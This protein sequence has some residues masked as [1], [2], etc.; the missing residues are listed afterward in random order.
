MNKTILSRESLLR[1]IAQYYAPETCQAIDFQMLIDYL[2]DREGADQ[3]LRELWGEGLVDPLSSETKP[4][5]GITQT[6]TPRIDGPIKPSNRFV[7]SKKG[8]EAV[9]ILFD[10]DRH[11]DSDGLPDA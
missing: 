3:V 8:F 7:I 2:G 5:G 4:S 6:E 9:E 1:W 10:P 11:P